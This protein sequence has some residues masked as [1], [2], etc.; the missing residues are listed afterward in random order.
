VSAVGSDK[1]TPFVTWADALVY[2]GFDDWRLAS[3]DIDGDATIVDCS[4]VSEA[5]CRDNEYG[6]MY[7]YNLA[8]TGKTGDQTTADGV[9]LNAIAREYRWGNFDYF[10]FALGMN[11]QGQISRAIAWAVRDGDSVQIPEPGSLS[12]LTIAFAYC[13]LAKLCSRKNAGPSN[14]GDRA[15]KC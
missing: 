2:G 5:N 13:T 3:M 12:L 9:T 7:F 8:G 10:S 15:P 1:W 11:T 6:Y 14:A 4:N